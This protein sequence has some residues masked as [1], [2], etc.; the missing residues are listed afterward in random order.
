MAAKELT[1]DNHRK[2]YIKRRVMKSIRKHIKMIWQEKAIVEDHESR[3]NAIDEFFV[4]LKEKA[5]SDEDRIKREKLERMQ[6]EVIKDKMKEISKAHRV[7]TEQRMTTPNIFSMDQYDTESSV[8][9]FITP[10]QVSQ[11][12]GDEMLEDTINFDQYKNE[13]TKAD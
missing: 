8:P 5:R 4:N 13:E 9:Y 2:R 1:A 11:I 12:G 10:S 7:G 6:K 3:K